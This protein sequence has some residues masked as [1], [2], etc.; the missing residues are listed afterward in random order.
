MEYPL[1]LSHLPFKTA[2]NGNH[3]ANS[4]QVAGYY[5]LAFYQS[6]QF[7]ITVIVIF[8]FVFLLSLFGNLIVLFVI[9]RHTRMRSYTNLFLAN[10]SFA[11]L[12]V[13]I[14][15]VLPLMHHLLADQWCCGQVFC[16]LYKLVET[17]NINASMLLLVV[18]AV[19]RYIAI[20]HPLKARQLFTRNK[21]CIVQ[22]SVWLVS[23]VN[24]IPNVMYYD[25]ITFNETNKLE[26]IC[27]YR[28]NNSKSMEIYYYCN[29]GIWYVLP[30]VTMTGLYVEIIR[31]LWGSNLATQVVSARA[32]ISSVVSSTTSDGNGDV[33]SNAN[34]KGVSVNNG[35]QSSSRVHETK[36]SE[37]LLDRN[38]L[39]LKTVSKL[40]DVKSATKFNF[41]NG[42]AS[43]AGFEKNGTERK[44]VRKVYRPDNRGHPRVGR[45]SRV[46]QVKRCVSNSSYDTDSSSETD[47]RP[48]EPG[49]HG[50]ERGRNSSGA[51]SVVM[52]QRRNSTHYASRLRVIRLLIVVLVTFAVLVLPNHLRLIGFRIPRFHMFTQTCQFLLYLNSALNPV[53]YSILSQT[54]RRYIRESF[55]C[56]KIWKT[57]RKSSVSKSS[58]SKS[59]VNK[60]TDSKKTLG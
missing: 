49:Q 7:R 10:L 58:V 31:T 23:G 24:A 17:I 41:G 47:A 43:D 57:L 1:N 15:C 33:E 30:L 20:K 27:F 53:M 2:V 25:V 32:R 16:K 26:S 45:R 3:I 18:I 34:V 46:C 40:Q 9:I 6:A 28:G 35:G 60:A 19:E 8:S 4:S 50:A 5:D 21:M 55:D 22:V 13:A 37:N 38:K 36:E 39:E 14:F 29:F 56:C 11:D 51:S 44:H 48:A 52:F 54:I 12:C 59:S 42:K